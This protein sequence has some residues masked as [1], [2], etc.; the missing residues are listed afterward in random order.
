M[1]LTADQQAKLARIVNEQQ[2]EQL[3]DAIDQGLEIPDYAWEPLPADMDLAKM[4]GQMS[5]IL[6]ELANEAHVSVDELRSA[7]FQEFDLEQKV[8]RAQNTATAA[9]HFLC[10]P[11][12]LDEPIDSQDQ[13]IRLLSWGYFNPKGPTVCELVL[14]VLASPDSVLLVIYRFHPFV[15]SGAVYG[16]FPAKVASDRTTIVKSLG[17]L[18]STNGSDEERLLGGPPSYVFVPEES[19]LS[20]SDIRPMF[21]SILADTSFSDLGRS[22]DLIKR[23]WCSPWNRAS[24]ELQNA[25]SSA[26]AGSRTKS[27]KAIPQARQTSMDAVFAQWWTLVTDSDH[28]AAEMGEIPAAWIG[29]K[30]HALGH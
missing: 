19:P 25:L 8:L 17:A 21:A 27:S 26:I 2:R 1:K 24:E 30:T 3:L 14:E 20:L 5:E 12:A 7:E 13:S 10:V 22:C 11:F 28:V 6:E 15:P 18:F 9:S 29:A 4:S 16:C 23:H